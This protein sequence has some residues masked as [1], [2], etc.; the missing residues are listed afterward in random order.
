MAAWCRER[1]ETGLIQPRHI[2]DVSTS[3]KHKEAALSHLFNVVST[4]SFNALRDR[5]VT[6]LVYTHKTSL[7][8]VEPFRNAVRC[9]FLLK[10]T[11]FTRCK[12][13][14]TSFQ[15]GKLNV[16]LLSFWTLYCIYCGSV[17]CQNTAD[18]Y[19]QYPDTKAAIAYLRFSSIRHT[20][21][22]DWQNRE[23]EE[24]K[25]WSQHSVWQRQIKKWKKVPNRHKELEKNRERQRWCN[26]GGRWGNE[27]L[28]QHIRS[29]QVITQVGKI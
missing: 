9:V 29:G 3:T 14:F 10:D 16:S 15:R 26:S 7:Y 17:N 21:R 23:Q 8:Y 13:M 27:T 22:L 4:Q 5:K 24:F 19:S 25:V 12:Y 18:L 1:R 2:S 6:T 20:V 28:M 11:I